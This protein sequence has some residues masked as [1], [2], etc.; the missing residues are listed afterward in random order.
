MKRLYDLDRA[1][2]LAIFL[3]VAGH[4]VANYDEGPRGVEWYRVFY[5][6]IYVFHM[7]FFMFV[8]GAIAGYSWHPLQT[9]SDYG[10]YVLR[11]GKRLLP[12]YFIFPII[13]FIAKNAAQY[14]HM[15]V[16]SPVHDLS[17]FVLIVLYPTESFSSFLWYIIVL[18][19]LYVALPVLLSVFRYRGSLLLLVACVL[20]FLPMP[21]MF[22]IHLFMEYLLFFLLGFSMMH[23]GKRKNQR[24]EAL[25]AHLDR[26]W[27]FWVAV[28]LTALAFTNHY[29]Y[30]EES[31]KVYKFFFGLLSIPALLGLVHGPL[32]AS[33]RILIILGFYTFPIYLMNTM[34]IGAVKSAMLRIAPWDGTNFLFYAPVLLASGVIFPILLKKYLFCYIPPLDKITH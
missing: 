12:A 6:H 27:L 11:R 16:D 33:S 25:L 22:A 26:W 23:N 2:G 10:G 24:Y 1:K 20:H 32:L 8:S 3:V 30:D 9:F 5:E 21:K 17:S 4:L 15:H 7:S 31:K 28:F 18:F 19:F 29:F 14:F 34:A 13:V